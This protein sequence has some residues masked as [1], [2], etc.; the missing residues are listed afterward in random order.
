MEIFFQ[1]YLERLQAL[2]HEIAE[3][4]AGLPQAALDWTPAPQANSIAVLVVH[5]VGAERYWMGDVGL[6]QPSGRDRAAEFLVAGI[7]SAELVAR[8]ESA[9]SYAR[10]AL[11]GLQVADLA[12]QRVSPRDGQGLTAGWA[13]LH[14]LE[15]S[16]IHLGHIQLTRQLWESAFPAG[17]AGH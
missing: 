3:A 1:D 9:S 5:L 15:H 10:T 17:D 2:H 13:L 7:S 8:L 16:A 6:G 4:I 12:A 11:Q 14:A